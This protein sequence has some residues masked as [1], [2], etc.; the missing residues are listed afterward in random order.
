MAKFE[1]REAVAAK[2]MWEGGVLESVDYGL[3]SGDMPDKELVAA[4]KKLEESYSYASA[5]AEAVRA[6]LPDDFED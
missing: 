5:D 3:K 6:L 1:S 2:I 4:W